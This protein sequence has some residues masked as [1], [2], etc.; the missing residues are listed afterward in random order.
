ML[1]NETAILQFLTAC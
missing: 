1:G